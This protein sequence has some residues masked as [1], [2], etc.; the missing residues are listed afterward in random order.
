MVEHAKDATRI[1]EIEV[2]GDRY[3]LDN[4]VKAA[5]IGMRKVTEIFVSRPTWA[6]LF[7]ENKAVQKVNNIYVAELVAAG[8]QLTDTIKNETRKL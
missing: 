7:R 1:D 6:D 8:L 4:Y 5:N 3:S 2:T